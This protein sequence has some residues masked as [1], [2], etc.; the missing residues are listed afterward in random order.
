MSIRLVVCENYFSDIKEAFADVGTDD[1]DLSVYQC[2]CDSQEKRERSILEIQRLCA[3]DDDVTILCSKKC[4]LEEITEIASRA[5]IKSHKDC[6]F[7]ITSDWMLDYI[8]THGGHVVGRSWL[9]DWTKHLH[10][11]GF[12]QVSARMHYRQYYSEI[13]C[14]GNSQDAQMAESMKAL[15]DYVGI[16]GRIM[17][18]D[19]NYLSYVLSSYL[20]ELRMKSD[21][22]LGAVSTEDLHR[23]LQGN[24]SNQL[25]VELIKA[26]S[27]EGIRSATRRLCLELF[28]ASDVTFLPCG[29]SD[30]VM[31]SDCAYRGSGEN[32]TVTVPIC[33]GHK[34]YG[35]LEIGTFLFPHHAAS[36]WEMMLHLGRI[37]AACLHQYEVFSC[38]QS[39]I[40]HLENEAVQKSSFLARMAHELRTPLHG[41]MGALQLLETTELTSLQNK[42]IS[43]SIQ[44]SKVLLQTISDILMYSRLEANKVEVTIASFSVKELIEDLQSVFFLDAQQKGIAFSIVL[45]DGFPEFLHTDLGKIREVLI[46][47]IGNAIKFT[48]EGR[49]TVTG[50]WQDANRRTQPSHVVFWVMDT[51]IGISKD[52]LPDIYKYFYQA[53]TTVSRQ[54]NGCGLGLAICKGLIELMGGSLSVTSEVG[55]GSVFELCIPIES[56]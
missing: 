6:C 21:F 47:L 44:S 48:V 55:V 24:A 32:L 22:T 53:D 1:I 56:T 34:A 45:A 28:G 4:R 15:S 3:E 46:N 50:I 43:M 42:Y 19:R 30:E 49:V 51:G 23:M 39:D 11:S 31:N 37:V 40:R 10:D 27:H 9:N 29:T 2:M 36:Y 12:D 17:D 26:D 52:C 8:Q 33:D 14:F 25:M 41:I 13:I 38:Y 16:P 35:Y 20:H 54:R 5:T 7:C 18:I